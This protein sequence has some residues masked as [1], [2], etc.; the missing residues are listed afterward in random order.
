MIQAIIFDFDGTIIDTEMPDYQTWQEMFQA[1]GAELSFDAWKNTVGKPD[2]YFDFYG[3]LEAECGHEVNREEVRIQRRARY[4]EL[5]GLQP[6]RPGIADYL[7]QAK[8][9]GLGLGIATSNTRQ[10]L[11]WYMERRNLHHYFDCIFTADDVEY[12]KPDPALYL[13]AVEAL[14]IQ[15]Q[16]AIAVEDSPT[17]AVAA[18]RAGLFT[19]AVPNAVTGQLT[20]EHTHLRLDSLA[21]MPLDDLLTLAAN[22]RDGREL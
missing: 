10:W 12:A 1:H 3:H 6:L 15:P 20:F 16:Q 14:N 9:L 8:C 2:G 7:S 19:V 5:V 11:T 13:M 4:R 21:D 22:G 17:G 18:M